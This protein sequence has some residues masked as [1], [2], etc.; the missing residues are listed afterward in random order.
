MGLQE[1]PHLGSREVDGHV[2]YARHPPIAIPSSSLPQRRPHPARQKPPISRGELGHPLHLLFTRHRAAQQGHQPARSR[3]CSSRHGLGPRQ[4]AAPRHLQDVYPLDLQLR[5]LH[6]GARGPP[7]RRQAEATARPERRPS[8]GDRLS[9]NGVVG[10]RPPGN[11]RRPRCG[12]HGYALLAIPRQRFTPSTSVQS[13]RFSSTWPTS[14]E[15]HLSQ[16]LSSIHPSAS[17][18]WRRS[19][20]P[21][22]SSQ[23]IHPHCTRRFVDSFLS[24]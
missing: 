4:R 10:S 3:S 23:E 8:A 6:L 14:Q 12:S 11:R 1:W 20:H 2:V 5:R 21:L 22:R 13:R 24:A 15:E 19:K 17:S 16:P 9:P 18:P 7:Q